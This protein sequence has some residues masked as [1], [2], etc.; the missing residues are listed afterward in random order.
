MW[1]LCTPTVQYW[2][3]NDILCSPSGKNT[4]KWIRKCFANSPD[5]SAQEGFLKYLI[6]GPK[7]IPNLFINTLEPK[8]HILT[9]QTPKILWWKSWIQLKADVQALF[10]TAFDLYQPPE[11]VHKHSTHTSFP[12]VWWFVFHTNKSSHIFTAARSKRWLLS[13]ILQQRCLSA[14]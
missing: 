9:L 1:L 14:K 10:F 7:Y 11:E 13:V 6:T 4:L 5:T 8:K 12:S 3:W 2:C